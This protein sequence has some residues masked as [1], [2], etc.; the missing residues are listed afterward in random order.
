VLIFIPLFLISNFLD[1]LPPPAMRS[2]IFLALVPALIAAAPADP[3][4][5]PQLTKDSV[6]GLKVVP[7]PLHDKL[8][9]A[10]GKLQA[11]L[12]NPKDAV[13]P[14]SSIAEIQTL[15][16]KVF[17][18][19]VVKKVRYGPFRLPPTS[20]SNWQKTALA[21]GG[22]ADEYVWPAIR[23]QC[24]MCWRTSTL[25]QHL[26]ICTKYYQ[27]MQGMPHR[28]IERRSRIRGRL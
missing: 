15:Q 8:F 6:P 11:V 14:S 23:S 7:K 18:D 20:E 4:K 27:A 24:K 26:Q 10:N 22:M 12:S 19:A 25:K 2:T 1:N 17:S 5:K 3:P 13:V 16:P 28:C 21:L 9:D